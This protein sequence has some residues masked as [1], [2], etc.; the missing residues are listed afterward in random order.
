MGPGEFL[1]INFF[2]AL[3]TLFN[4]IAVFLV[5]KHFLFQPCLQS[6]NRCFAP[7]FCAKIKV[8]HG[9]LVF[10]RKKLYNMIEYNGIVLSLMREMEFL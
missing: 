6:R 2:T 5:L 1:N 3:F 9:G 10:L 7:F 4:F 8:S